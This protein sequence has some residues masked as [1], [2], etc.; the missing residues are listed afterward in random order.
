MIRCR[1]ID[2]V[3]NAPNKYSKNLIKVRL[4]YNLIDC[5]SSITGE[6]NKVGLVYL[7]CYLLSIIVF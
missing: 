5:C 4:K 6:R 3:Y 2:E 7:F 1:K